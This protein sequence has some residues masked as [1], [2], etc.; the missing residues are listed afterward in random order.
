MSTGTY[1]E[2]E[3]AS[4]SR[5]K[6]GVVQWNVPYLVKSR[7]M[8]NSVPSTYQGCSKV[9]STWTC[10]N[11]GTNPSYI[12]TVTYEGPDN[13]SMDGSGGGGSDEYNRPIWS[14]D[15]DLQEM[16]IE[17]HWNFPAIKAKYGGKPDPDSPDLWIFPDEMPS[18][19]GKSTGLS[20]DDS[21]EGKPNPMKGVRTYVVMITRVSKSYTKRS[22]P[23]VVS[24][25]G[26]Q[27]GSIPGAPA[28][29]NALSWGQRTW[30]QMPPQVSKRGRVWEITESWRLSEHF[31]WPD[32]VYEK[33]SK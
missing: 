24:K 32:K 1:K 11:N 33:F 10:N 30:I 27:S 18:G 5:S 29:F 16:P 20:K 28:S 19:G 21:G 17:S 12:V 15:F 8:V 22:E 31:E 7:A 13:E 23:N 9:A 2:I 14:I 25:I 4:G 26:K 3:G 6:E